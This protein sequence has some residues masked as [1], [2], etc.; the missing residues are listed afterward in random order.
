M[1]IFRSLILALVAT[2]VALT[3]TIAASASDSSPVPIAK[4]TGSISPS[5]HLSP[6]TPISFTLDT[7]FASDPPGGDFV[8]QRLDYLFPYGTVVNGRLFPS[9]DAATLARTHGRLSACPKG[10]KIGGGTAAGTAVALGVTSHA[11]VTLFNGPG[12]HSITMNVSITTPAL[13]NAT[14]SAPFRTLHGRRYASELTVVVPDSLK[15][16]LD[17]D[18][19]TSDIHIATGATRMVHG[20][21]RGYVEA[22]HCPSSGRAQIHGTFTFGGGVAASADTTV[23]C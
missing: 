2:A 3:G 12:G 13:I 7:R 11:V 8:L 17:G 16:I 1:S 4:L 14:Y 21:K 9:C 6:G 22:Q 5:R 20:V 15:R 19:V 18:I 23:P 10:S